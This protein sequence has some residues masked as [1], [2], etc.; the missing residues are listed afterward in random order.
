MSK[1]QT[2]ER[3]ISSFFTKQSRIEFPE[4]A[5]VYRVARHHDLRGHTF[6][7]NIINSEKATKA[8]S[9]WEIEKRLS[10][11]TRK[12]QICVTHADFPQVYP[13]IK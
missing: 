2:C 6:N 5:V 12:V 9:W 10:V 11:A 4:N 8:G 7:T 3:E 1:R 13:Y